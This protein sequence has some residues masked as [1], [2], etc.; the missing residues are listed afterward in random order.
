MSNLQIR[1]HFQQNSAGPVN[2]VKNQ[3]DQ[4]EEYPQCKFKLH[5]ISGS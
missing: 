3:C 2:G 4:P 1:Y 5:T